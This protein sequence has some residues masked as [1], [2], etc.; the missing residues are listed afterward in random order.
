M[1]SKPA[2]NA[3]LKTLEEPPARVVFVMAT[4]ELH[5]VLPTILS[6]CQQFDFRKVGVREIADQLAMIA[7]AEMVKAPR[8]A[9]E[10]LARAGDGSVRDAESLLDQ[11][12][13]FCGSELGEAEVRSLLGLVPEETVEAFLA[14][15]ADK[16]AGGLVRMIEAATSEGHD[17]RIFHAGLVE[18]VRRL[19]VLK[20][21]P[22]EDATAAR[23]ASDP[24]RRRRGSW[25]SPTRTGSGSQRSR[26]GSRPTG[27]CAPSRSSPRSRRRSSTPSSRAT[28]S[29][30][31]RSASRPSP[32]SRRSRSSSRGST[33]ASRR[34]AVLRAVP[35]RQ[36]LPR[37]RRPF[38]TRASRSPD[39]P[40]RA[41][42][43]RRPR[44]ADAQRGRDRRIPR[45]RR[46]P[47]RNSASRPSRTRRSPSTR[48]APG[49]EG[50]Q[51][52]EARAFLSRTR[53]RKEALSKL[54]E[55]ASS[56]VLEGRKLVVLFDDAQSFLRKSAE[57]PANV[58]ILKEIAAS[59]LGPGGTVEIRRAE[60][61]P[62]SSAAAGMPLSPDSASEPAA[63]EAE[64]GLFDPPDEPEAE[65]LSGPS[66][67][68]DR[69][70]S[71]APAQTPPAPAPPAGATGAR[72]QRL[73]A[74]ALED[75]VVK[76]LVSR[77]GGRIVEIKE[78]P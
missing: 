17:L 26:N 7:K 73:H 31:R 62:R 63:D 69:P 4:T 21:L 14:G 59:V 33:P 12:I 29:R 60:T 76:G 27:C 40:R 10:M 15:V 32:S 25:G 36:A 71:P 9:L 53:E 70:S 18:G 8:A 45:P 38:P 47:P 2:F 6:R 5:K 3:L 54:V 78:V 1:L 61:A 51:S 35:P 24:P 77:F 64:S 49:F 67:P 50:S 55:H 56:V 11:A 75:P 41:R 30:P 39:D 16:D 34:A 44:A 48:P 19:L 66:G 42:P 72:Y 37:A 46:G 13:A 65:L 57:Q 58:A 23:D 68:A 20:S 28:C 74:Q 22:A 43:S 52:P